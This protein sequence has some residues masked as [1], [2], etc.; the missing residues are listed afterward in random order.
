MSPSYVSNNLKYTMTSQLF[1]TKTAFNCKQ[2]G[3]SV[4]YPVHAWIEENC[5]PHNASWIPNPNVVQFYELQEGV[6]R[7]MR[8]VDQPSLHGGDLA[9]TSFKIVASM[10]RE[11]WNVGYVPIQCVRVGR[12]DHLSMAPYM[13]LEDHKPVD[14]PRDGDRIVVTKRGAAA[15][16]GGTRT[17]TCPYRS[18]SAGEE[19]EV[20]NG[21]VSRPGVE[22]R[23][24]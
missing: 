10:A 14:L 8:N 22:D 7:D 13:Q 17:D 24:Q 6:L 15:T 20:Q 12:I 11:T 2:D 4:G 9:K 5:Y 23:Q 3:Y 1:Q 21:S 18:E 19:R 16:V